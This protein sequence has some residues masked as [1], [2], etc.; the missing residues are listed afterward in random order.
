MEYDLA[1]SI[2]DNGHDVPIDTETKQC[3][4][5]HIVEDNNGPYKVVRIYI[6]YRE[7]F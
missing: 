3:I 6:I 7:N 1:K 2:F 4:D 5:R